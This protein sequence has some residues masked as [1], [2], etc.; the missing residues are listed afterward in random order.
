MLQNIGDILRDA[1][2]DSDVLARY[3]GDEFTAILPETDAQGAMIVAERV[4]SAVLEHPFASEVGTIPVTVSIGVASHPPITDRNTLLRTADDAL[5]VG[6]RAG[7]NQV[8]AGA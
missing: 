3:G 4:R 5:Y 8:V 7:K 1:T 6:K 2:R